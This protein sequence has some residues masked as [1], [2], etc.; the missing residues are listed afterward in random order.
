MV[1]GGRQPHT[2]DWRQRRRHLRL[3]PT[4]PSSSQAVRSHSRLLD[5]QP[6]DTGRTLQAGI[7]RHL[8]R[9]HTVR[10]VSQVLASLFMV[11]LCNRETIYI[12]ILFLLSSF[13]FFFLA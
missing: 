3:R 11:A 1:T 7:Y 2:D 5:G 9:V 12:F 4:R 8:I 10:R 13:F 6:P